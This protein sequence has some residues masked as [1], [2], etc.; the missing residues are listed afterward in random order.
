MASEMENFNLPLPLTSLIG[1]E[2]QVAN[3]RQRLLRADVRLL[4]LTGTGG[5]GKT[6]LAIQVTQEIA[7]HFRDGVAFVSLAHVQDPG[8]VIAAIGQ[9]LGLRE[10]GSLPIFEQLKSHLRSR[11]VLLLL[12]NFE[13]VLDAAVQ[14]AELLGACPG[15]KCLV[16]SRIPL[17]LSG[18]HQVPVPPLALPDRQQPT[19]PKRLA[20]VD[21]VRLFVQRAAAVRPDFQLTEANAVV[22]SDICR[23]LEGLPLAV[24]LAASLVKVLPLPAIRSRLEHRLHVLVGGPRDLPPRQQTLRNTIA[25]SYNLL[26]SEEQQLFRRL[27][28]F[29][30]GCSEGEIGKV[31]SIQNTVNRDPTKPGSKD[32]VQ[33]LPALLNS[34]VDKS[35]L[36][37]IA[38]EENEPRYVML[39]TVREYAL[40][41][42]EAEG[43]VE[44]LRQAHAVIFLALA[45]EGEAGLK[46]AE[47]EY[48]L[49]RLEREHDN[50]RT[51]LR[52][53]SDHKETETLLR[54]CGAMGR[55]WFMHGHLSEGRRW[56]EEVLAKSESEFG[57]VR[58]DRADRS[59]I[60]YQKSAILALAKALNAAGLLARYQANYSRASAL[61]GESLQWYRLLNDPHGI[62]AA[63]DNLAAVARNGGNYPA[64]RAMYE[65]SLAISH[66]LDDR[67]GIAQTTIYLGIAIWYQ[68][69]P[70]GAQTL[71]EEGLAL[72]RLLGTRWDI[73]LA[74]V[75]LGS[76]LRDQRE[77]AK[78]AVLAQ[79]ALAVMR[80][81][82]DRRMVALALLLAGE[83]LAG[84][85]EGKAAVI[86]A[87]AHYKEACQI[88]GELGDRYNMAGSIVSVAYV[89]AQALPDRSVQLL[90]AH[91]SLCQSIKLQ[92]PDIERR[93][94]ELRLAQLR[95]GLEEAKFTAALAAG[96]VMTWEEAIQY[97]LETLDLALVEMTKNSEKGTSPVPGR[98]G[99]NLPAG[100]TARE[101]EVLRLVASGLTDAQVAKKLVISYRTANTH[102]TSIFNKLGVSSRLAATRFALD[103]HLL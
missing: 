23:R 30:G 5:I 26:N 43:D 62:T 46:T 35:L 31:Y 84:Q 49:G 52:W 48:W 39:E 59:T 40:E 64:A 11:Q 10:A 102:M 33:I 19:D 44:A 79:E 93:E 91:N 81:L 96:Q 41:R 68:G 22:V 97:A 24:E 85:G 98:P 50:L 82:G 16:T 56:A 86:Q 37:Q 34:L 66:S 9:S 17:H 1:R 13:H 74:L 57:I 94:I 100:L 101:L 87:I 6:R 69:D 80:K 8:L 75:V 47:Q 71:V 25:W 89:T 27:A 2:R 3:L 18:E 29:V 14:I 4:T 53:L 54:L 90:S 60:N 12:D 72:F 28:V 45:E 99:I 103:H 76:I 36:Q 42:F 32:D 55:F 88:F 95:A 61:C 77:Y 63:L 20:Q 70:A 67:W 92:F 51:A 73:A 83:A 15:L 78:A 38:R 21:T 7:P 65:E 58:S